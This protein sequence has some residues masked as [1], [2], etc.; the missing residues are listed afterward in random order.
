MPMFIILY[1]IAMGGYTGQKWASHN[2][3]LSLQ[4]LYTFS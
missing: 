1:C 3:G 2:T 4:L